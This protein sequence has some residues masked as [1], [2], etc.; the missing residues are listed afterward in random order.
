MIAQQT[1]PLTQSLIGLVVLGLSG[2]FQG[3]SANT[4]I[5]GQTGGEVNAP[6]C[7]E[8]TETVGW[9]ASPLGF[10]AAEAALVLQFGET[11]TVSPNWLPPADPERVTYVTPAANTTL[12]FVL[13]VVTNEAH[14]VH[15][16]LA[17][18][19]SGAQNAVGL[20]DDPCRNRLE[21]QVHVTMTTSTGALNEAFDATLRVFSLEEAMLDKI[22]DASALSGNL[23]PAPTNAT[24]D[25]L[26][27]AL[28]L[29]FGAATTPP[30]GSLA[31]DSSS[32][33]GATASYTSSTVATW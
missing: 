29:Q 9:S 16:R 4:S 6:L 17:T 23:N 30:E 32:V 10:S 8:E 18:D 21:L 12:S 22:L 19:G 24:V 28:R 2:V 11:L 31:L 3:C 13:G 25:E 15:S 7:V 33:D 26:D 5:G 27:L 20:A 14:L 1:Y